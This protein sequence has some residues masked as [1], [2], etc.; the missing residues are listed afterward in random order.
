MTTDIQ[1]A[2]DRECQTTINHPGGRRVAGWLN[3]F[4]LQN[5]LKPRDMEGGV[6]LR[7]SRQSEV[8]CQGIHH[9]LHHES[10][11]KPGRHVLEFDL[12][13]EL[14]GGKSN[15]L[16]STI[17]R[18]LNPVMTGLCLGLQG[19]GMNSKQHGPTSTH[20]CSGTDSPAQKEPSEHG[21]LCVADPLLH[22]PDCRSHKTR[23]KDGAGLWIRSVDL[24]PQK[25]SN[26]ERPV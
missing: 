24:R 2:L 7:W 15:L 11:D 16:T 19:R 3:Q 10:T 5:L 14:L 22:V 26:T 4:R 21:T 8:H 13:K 17:Q 18:S 23:R 25:T 6:A 9:A 20:S 12:E 1:D